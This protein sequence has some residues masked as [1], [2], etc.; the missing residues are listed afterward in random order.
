M[1]LGVKCVSV[2]VIACILCTLFMIPV[3][4]A[5]NVI[6]NGYPIESLYGWSAAPPYGT[7]LSFSPGGV[8]VFFTSNPSGRTLGFN[9]DTFDLRADSKYSFDFKYW[10]GEYVN[11]EVTIQITHVATGALLVNSRRMTAQNGENNF[12]ADFYCSASGA[13]NL[14]V[15]AT[16]TN[17]LPVSSAFVRVERALL[18]AY[19]PRP[20]TSSKADDASSK[21]QKAQ[22]DALGG[23]T[24]EEIQSEVEGAIDFDMDSWDNETTGSMRLFVVN[25]MNGFGPEYA[26]IL[27]FS[28]VMGLAIFIIGKKSN[29]D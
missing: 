1:K 20:D 4:A 7:Q 2:V 3:S 25:V 24:D 14:Y 27:L 8:R 21:T 28:C 12:K 17:V 26:S 19:S 10:L 16:G 29:K 18:T 15:V 23:K 13:Y 11:P 22:D 9:Y 6:T 5:E